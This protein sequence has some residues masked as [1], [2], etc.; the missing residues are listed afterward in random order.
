M[1]KWSNCEDESENGK[2]HLEKRKKLKKRMKRGIE[3]EG[4][5]GA[6]MDLA[7]L[8]QQ[9]LSLFSLSPFVAE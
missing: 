3:E 2:R 4:N 5:R 9:K 1:L 6:K 8:Q 7:D